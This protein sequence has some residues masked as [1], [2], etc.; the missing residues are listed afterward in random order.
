MSAVNVTVNDA[1]FS[2]Q[3]RRYALARR[4]DFAKAIRQQARLVAVNLA[5]Q[6]QPF[7]DGASARQA[8]EGAVNTEVQRVYKTVPYTAVKVRDSGKNPSGVARV[9]TA[10]QAA[11]AFVRYVREGKNDKAGELL[12]NLKIEPFLATTVGTFD[13]GQKHQGARHGARRKVPK[14]QFVRRVV[15]NEAQMKS[16]LKKIM[17]RVGT[18]KAGWASC[19]QQLGGMRGIPG[20][21][22]R[23]AR[24]TQLGSVH[25]ATGGQGR[26]QFVRMD[27]R[28]PWIDKC[29]NAGQIQRALDIQKGKM[30]NA[31]RLT[32]QRS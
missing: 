24:K 26:E 20:W 27:N 13:G 25:D 5:H 10:P 29:L 19:A 8:G 30:I 14:N 21:V 11:A 17:Q 16:Y 15:K 7:G 12:D 18:A 31:I 2:R 22:T 1:D 32:L 28:V 23:H 6:T 9:K 4:I 3:L